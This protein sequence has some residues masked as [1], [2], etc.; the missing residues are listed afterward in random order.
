MPSFEDHA[1]TLAGV[2]L[3]GD[4]PSVDEAIEAGQ[5]ALT[6]A[7]SLVDTFRHNGAELSGCVNVG[8]L[9][10]LFDAHMSE[11]RAAAVLLADYP[12]SADRSRTIH[13]E[14][15]A[16]ISAGTNG[17]DPRTAAGFQKLARRI[18][19]TKEH[20]TRLGKVLEDLSV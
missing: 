2:E 20:L 12:D 3:M 11:L 10:N 7:Q 18:E 4:Y 1:N 17:A 9:E 6:F 19:L 13:N 16:A 5:E 8:D 15:V 14:L